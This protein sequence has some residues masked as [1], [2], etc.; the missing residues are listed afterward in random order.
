M[1]SFL[2]DFD[3]REG[4]LHP[5]QDH[6]R[7]YNPTQAAF[8]EVSSRIL[9]TLND[10]TT[11]MKLQGSRGSIED[12]NRLI[13]TI[14]NRQSMP[15]QPRATPQQAKSNVASNRNSKHTQKKSSKNTPAVQI[16]P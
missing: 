6:Y 8:D 7:T 1:S 14:S 11:P 3:L 4:G 12:A 15:G 16:I 10:E 13:T 9:H 5:T 2:Q